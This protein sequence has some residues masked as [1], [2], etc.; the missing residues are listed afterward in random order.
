M[1]SPT[2][3]VDIQ[4]TVPTQ[5]A[6]ALRP[7]NFKPHFQ[8]SGKV[9][10]ALVRQQAQST[11]SGTWQ[12]F[13]L[14]KYFGEEA[15]SLPFRELVLPL[16]WAAR[17]LLISRVGARYHRLAPPQRVE[18]ELGLLIKLNAALAGTCQTSAQPEF[19]GVAIAHE[20]AFQMA[21]LGTFMESLPSLRDTIEIA[22]HWVDSV[23]EFLDIL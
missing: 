19:C 8:D 22:A 14:E 16:V 15:R 10:L 4:P 7:A 12:R 2:V 9:L 21:L 20:R 11:Q 13:Q 17:Q 5:A 18:L 1:N 6:I 3:C 23:E